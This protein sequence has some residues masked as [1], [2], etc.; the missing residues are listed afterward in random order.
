MPFVPIPEAFEKE[1]RLMF[2][3]KNPS[4]PHVVFSGN[5]TITALGQED[6]DFFNET[7]VHIEVGPFWKDVQSVAPFVT[8]SAFNNSNADDDDE[9][10]WAISKLT[11]D[12]IGGTGPQIDEERIRLKFVVSAK[13]E[14]SNAFGI[15]YYVTARGRELGAGGL[16]VP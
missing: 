12:T 16:M 5:V 1:H 8:I 15:G 9:Q 14:N 13:G 6:E 3:A 2:E 11:W 7:E 4:G 10:G